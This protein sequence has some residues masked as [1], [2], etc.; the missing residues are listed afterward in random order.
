M[1]I[2]LYSNQKELLVVRELDNYAA[3]TPEEEAERLITYVH[4]KLYAF[5]GRRQVDLFWG[6]ANASASAWLR[7][8]RMRNI[9]LLVHSH[10]TVREWERFAMDCRL[11][12]AGSRQN[13]QGQCH[14][15]TLSSERQRGG[16]C[17]PGGV[18]AD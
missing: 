9:E 10:L 7:P 6:S 5:V 13:L 11:A 16:S 14:W 3:L 17:T 2:H 15:R 8:G 12:I 18:M 1:P 4:A